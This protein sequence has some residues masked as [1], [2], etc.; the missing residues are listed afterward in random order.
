MKI[1]SINTE[2]TT[3]TV[4]VKSF[5]SELSEMKKTYQGLETS[6][7]SLLSEVKK[8]KG[9]RDISFKISIEIFTIV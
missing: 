8:K 1:E 9:V 2:I 3:T 5:N 4:E 6:L 7:Q